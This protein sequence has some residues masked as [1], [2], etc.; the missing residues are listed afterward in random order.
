M[1]PHILFAE[2]DQD[3][4]ELVQLFLRK[5]GFHVSATGTPADV[6]EL[7]ATKLIKRPQF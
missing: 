3:T 4:R 7:A 2:D 1:Q 6:L 5:A